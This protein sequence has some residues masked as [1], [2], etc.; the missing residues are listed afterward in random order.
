V[1]VAMLGPLREPLAARLMR[2]LHAAGRGSAAL[3]VYGR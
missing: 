2:A 3:E 1:Q